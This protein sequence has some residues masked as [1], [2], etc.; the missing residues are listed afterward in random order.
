MEQIIIQSICVH[1]EDNQAISNTRHGFVKNKSCQTNLRS[2]FDR[3]TSLVDRGEA[4]DVVYLDLSKAF[5]TVSH[6]LLINKPEKSSLDQPTRR[7]VHIWLENRSQGAGVSGSQ[8]SWK[9]PSSGVLEGSVLGPVLFSV[10]D[11][12]IENALIKS[13][14][15]T[16]LGG[17]ASCHSLPGPG[18]SQLRTAP[19][20]NPPV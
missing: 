20:T 7:W 9:D 1:R 3:V 17:V 19:G 5:D 8:S 6:D 11:N 2:F 12:D 18:L 15:N 16:R 14:D 10:L 13:E 4:V